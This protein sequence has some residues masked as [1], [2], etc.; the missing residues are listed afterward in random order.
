MVVLVAAV[1]VQHTVHREAQEE[2]V[3]PQM[4][5]QVNPR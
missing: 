2:Q 1:A 3:V 5:R 4:E